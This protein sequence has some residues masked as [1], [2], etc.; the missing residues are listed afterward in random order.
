MKKWTLNMNFVRR[1]EGAAAACQA[2]RAAEGSSIT[3]KEGSGLVLV[4]TSQNKKYMLQTVTLKVGAY[5]E[6]FSSPRGRN[7]QLRNDH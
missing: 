4:S 5:K 7:Y 6:A 1:Q 3:G 2:A